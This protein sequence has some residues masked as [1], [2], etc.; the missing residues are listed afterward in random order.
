M[1]WFQLVTALLPVVEEIF[2]SV[3]SA[4]A[5]GKTPETIHANIVDHVAALPGVIRAS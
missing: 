1:N 3:E 5:A 2:K 4:K